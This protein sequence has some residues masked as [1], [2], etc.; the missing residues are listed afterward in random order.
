M[1]YL[2]PASVSRRFS[3]KNAPTIEQEEKMQSRIAVADSWV[4]MDFGR[5]VR[6]AKELLEQDVHPPRH[7]R[8]EEVLSQ[9][10]QRLLLLPS[11]F[12]ALA[13][14]V[15]FG[16]GALGR[17][18]SPLLLVLLVGHG[19]LESHDELRSR[20]LSPGHGG[21][22]ARGLRGRRHD[23]EH[24]QGTIPPRLFVRRLRRE[25]DCDSRCVAAETN[26]RLVASRKEGRGRGITIA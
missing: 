7:L 22:Q 21:K 3:I 2:Q 9:P 10:I 6:W 15:A 23:S 4:H 1:V 18:I 20:E 11:V 5:D 26:V 13:Q 19:H 16:R 12:P 24:R 17:G 25:A 14:A 8:E